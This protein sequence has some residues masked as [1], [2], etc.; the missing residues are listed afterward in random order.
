MRTRLCTP[1][2]G[3]LNIL[4]ALPVTASCAEALRNGPNKLAASQPIQQPIIIA[5]LLAAFS[6]FDIAPG[7]T[8]TNHYL[9]QYVPFVFW[10]Y[11]STLWSHRPKPRQ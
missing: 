3:A 9:P 11:I 6:Y 8:L 7:L 4:C 1:K 10:G 2:T 5:A